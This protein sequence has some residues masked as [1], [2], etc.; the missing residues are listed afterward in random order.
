MAKKQSWREYLNGV[1]EKIHKI[2]PEWEEKLG[3]GNILIPAP[4]DIERIIKLVGKGKLI[5]VDM[6]REQLA[7]EKGVRLTAAAP[8]SIYL[9]KIALASEEE[10]Q[11]NNK[12]ITAYWRVLKANGLVNEKFPGGLEKQQALLQQEGHQIELFGKRKK[13]PK[14]VD[15]EKCLVDLK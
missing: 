5:T 7:K 10:E 8:T 4:K 14:V 15:Y 11:L 13:V 9:K 3:N 1:E 6:I 2:T 12:E